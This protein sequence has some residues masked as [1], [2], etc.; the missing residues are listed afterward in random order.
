MK[1]E[2]IR[3]EK[4]NFPISL[5]C[6]VL[7]VSRSGFYAWARRPVAPRKAKQAVLTAKVKA[8][9]ERS[10]GIYGSPRVHRDLQAQGVVVSRKTVAK[11]MKSAGIQGRS[12]RRF[13][14]TTDSRHADPIAPNILDRQFE[15]Q[16]PNEVWVTDVTAIATWEGWLYLA[17]IL[18][19]YS[20]RVVAWA[21]S[22]NNDTNLALEALHV[23]TR[24]RQPPRGLLHHS[25]RGS[26]YASG[27]YRKALDD[28]GMVQSMSRK[29]D[30]WDNAVAES[31]FATLR[32]ELVDH[33]T[34]PTR[35]VAKRSLADYID[36]FYNIQRRHSSIGY[37][38][39]V[40]HELHF[41]VKRKAA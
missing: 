39:P 21:S 20:R 36:S 27:A 18:D 10:R 23:A 22:A 26:P 33:I 1:F 15:V 38:N 41:A 12:K 28:G 16:A 7:D 3:V 13:K 32:A 6:G 11:A 40:E 4:G 5:I 25:D 30:C 2:F 17:V 31:F 9:H 8:A 37:A 29:G 14:R 35:A 19:L 24:R 34:C